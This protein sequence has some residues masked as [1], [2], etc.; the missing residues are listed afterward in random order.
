MVMYALCGCERKIVVDFALWVAT[1]TL[2]NQMA[3]FGNELNKTEEECRKIR[4]YGIH[5]LR[6]T[7][8]MKLLSELPEDFAKNDLI[9]LRRKYGVEG[10]CAYIISRWLKAGIVEKQGNR[11]RKRQR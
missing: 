11:F 6:K 10:E 5:Q 4:M 2:N 1:E 7:K 9:I 3:F 8:N